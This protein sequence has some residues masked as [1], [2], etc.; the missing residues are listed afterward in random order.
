MTENGNFHLVGIRLH[1]KDGDAY[2]A[3]IAR[4]REIALCDLVE[5]NSFKPLLSPGGPYELDLGIEEN[6]LIFN[7]KLA[8]GE[9]HGTFIMSL[10]PLRRVIKD[11][12]AICDSYDN[13]IA[14]LPPDKL[15]AIDMARRG[16]HDEGAFILQERLSSKICVDGDTAR[17]LFT[18]ICVLH[19]KG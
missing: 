15:E 14:K 16:I 9:H 13:A 7:L 4:E 8:G 19:L 12:F 1:Q 6:R 5:C 18:L 2:S 11:Y 10:T 17:R 3:E